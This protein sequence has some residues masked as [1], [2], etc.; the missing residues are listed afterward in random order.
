MSRLIFIAILVMSVKLLSQNSRVITK[1]NMLWL[2]YY[3]TI[4][5]NPKWSVNSDFQFRTKN[6]YHDHSQA[7]GRTGLS[8]KFNNK[9]TA[10]I[11]FAHFRFFITNE[12]SRAEWRPWQEI[13]L[14]DNINN[15][16]LSHRFRLEQRFNEKVKNNEPLSEY[17]FNYRLRYR[18]DLRFPIVKKEKK[19]KILYVLIGNEL[20]INAGKNIIYNYFDQNRSY[21]GL[22]YELNKKVSLQ[23]QYIHIW[24]QL[25]SGYDFL[26]SEVIRFNI[27]H[28]INL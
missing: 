18:L 13:L 21:A 8:Y 2:G 19:G 14:N 4:N 28:T 7:L 9:I 17:Q 26:M 3:N 15:L 12:F 27:Y 16:K 5:F 23:L 10:T 24:Q 1:D 22:N 11:G 25:S 6:W 20:M